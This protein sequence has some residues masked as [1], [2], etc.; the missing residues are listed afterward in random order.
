MILLTEEQIER[1]SRQILLKDVGGMGQD[2]LLK[3]KVLIIGVGG[4]GS[5]IAL[6]LAAAGIGTIGIVDSDTVE[7]SNLQRQILH[8]TPDLNK[9]KVESAKEKLE[10]INPDVKVNVHYTRVTAE[11]ISDLI[12]EY[13]FIIEGTDNFSSKFLINDACIFLDKPFSQCGILRFDGQT[14]THIIGTACYRC[15][16][17]SPPPK[18]I[19]PSCSEA[20]VLGAVAGILGTIQAAE[21]LKFILGIGDLLT[22]RILMVDA[23]NMEFRSISVQRNPNCPICGENPTITELKEFEQPVCDLN[24]K[25]L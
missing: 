25:S 14:M 7:L 3:A 8:F 6:Y 2:K 13:D 21:A 23:F 18:G 11:N 4:L 19:V 24:M 16:F 10:L 20:G 15:V 9:P 12:K 22:N 17:H 5:P 1:Y